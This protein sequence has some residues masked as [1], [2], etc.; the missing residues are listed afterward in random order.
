MAKPLCLGSG[1]TVLPSDYVATN[2]PYDAALDWASIYGGSNADIK[3]A[4]PDAPSD[5]SLGYPPTIP[6]AKAATAAAVVSVGAG[7][8]LGAIGIVAWRKY[9]GTT[10]KKRNRRR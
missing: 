10:N 5:P 7:I 8:L 2:K 6:Q 9:R 3:L 1:G 4:E